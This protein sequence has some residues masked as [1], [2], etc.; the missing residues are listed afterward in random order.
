[1]DTV[2]VVYAVDAMNAGDAVDAV[3]GVNAMNAG[4]AVDAVYAV[5]TVYAV[6]VVNVGGDPHNDLSLW[7]ECSGHSGWAHRMQWMQWVQCT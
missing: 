3:Y 4:G 6:D 2:D 7:S 5:D 1:M